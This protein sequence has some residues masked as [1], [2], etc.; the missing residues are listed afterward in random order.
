MVADKRTHLGAGH[1]GTLDLSCA[2]AVTGWVDDVI[3]S[4]GD[5]VISIGVA[6]ASITGEVVA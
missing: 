5:P 1:K 4:T 2:D 6:A 3:H